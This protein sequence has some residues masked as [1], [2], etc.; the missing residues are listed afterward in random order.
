MTASMLPMTLYQGKEAERGDDVKNTPVVYGL[1]SIGFVGTS[2]G[3][4]SSNGHRA[5]VFL[6]WMGGLRFLAN[7]IAKKVGSQ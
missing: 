5:D 3:D 4:R 1:P 6:D 7:A 2:Y